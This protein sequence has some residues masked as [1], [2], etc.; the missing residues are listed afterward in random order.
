MRPGREKIR[1]EVVRKERSSPRER[2]R[3]WIVAATAVGLVLIL[4]FLLQGNR[5]ELRYERYR[6]Q[7]AESYQKG[8][9]DQ[10]LSDLRKAEAIR[11]SEDVRMLMADCYESQGNWDMALKTLRQMDLNDAAVK[12]R[13]GSLEQRKLQQRE[14][15][16]RIVAGESYDADCAELDLSGRD[17]GN[18]AL[19]ELLQLHALT[20]LSLADNRI[21]DVEALQALGGLRELDLSGNEISGIDALGKLSNLRSLKLDRNPLED[22]SPLGTLENLN[23]LSLLGITLPEGEL[24]NLS[25]ALPHCSILTDGEKEGTVRICLSGVAFD[26]TVTSLSL[27]GLGLRE[28]GSLSL[29]TGLKS[30]DL[31]DNEISDLSPLMALQS[32]EQLKLSGNQISDLRP[33]IGL[34]R[35][36]FLDASRN[37][38]SET[39]AVGSIVT[40]QNLD[41]SDNPIGDFSGLKKL[42]DMRNLRLENTGMGD[43]ALPMLYGMTRMSRLALERNEGISAEAMNRLQSKLPDCGISYGTLVYIVQ[44]GGEDYRTDIRSLCI[45]GT[46]LSDLFGFEKFDCLETVQLGRNRIENLS[47]FQNAHCRDSI[48]ELD[49][50]FNRIQ[51]LG[52]LA[53]LSGLETLDL[54]SNQISSLRPLQ[55]LTQLKKLNLSGNPL[56]AEQIQELRQ[57]LPDCEIEF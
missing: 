46:E 12:E 4:A 30:L 20:T 10:A 49:L 57:A 34:P 28:I 27:K 2:R 15:G 39:S 44:L 53:A 31:S 45:E 37:S 47:P 11:S 55:R 23:S 14:D 16:Q 35:L 42:S 48:K 51:D 22:L 17:L 5:E 56:T 32:L 24:E 25:A 8:D 43:E 6:R 21:S 41:L 54:R 36:R 40:L 9:Y 18:G 13:I 7:A 52:P 1:I 26:S 38:V 29:C 50:S 3:Y 33:L 19:Q